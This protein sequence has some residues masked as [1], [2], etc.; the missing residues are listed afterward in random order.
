[1]HEVAAGEIDESFFWVEDFENLL[2]VGFR[3]L[4]NLL[5]RQLF[6][7]CRAARWV[8]DQPGKVTDE[9]DY[10]VSQILKVL[11]LPDQNRVADMDVRC[12][13]VETGL[14]SQRLSGFLR[15]LEL[16][17]Q[18][19]FGDDLDRDPANAL[20]LLLDRNCFEVVHLLRIRTRLPST[21]HLPDSTKSIA[22]EWV[23]CS[24]F[25]ILSD[26]VSALSPPNTGTT[27]CAMIGPPSS[28][29]STKWTV[30]P[31]NFTP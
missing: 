24:S 18:F 15:A 9:K 5:R 29:S 23:L 6:S 7:C 12:C 22:S 11:H 14:N 13:G 21:S 31:L 30:Q 8:P 3:V 28:V 2:L 19:F 20:E 16:L 10:C 25:R 17:D 4:L 1:G 27:A 26:T